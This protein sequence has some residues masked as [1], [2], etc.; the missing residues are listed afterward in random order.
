VVKYIKLK[1]PNKWKVTMRKSIL[2][3]SILIFFSVYVLNNIATGQTESKVTEITESQNQTQKTE[4]EQSKT[5][6]DEVTKQQMETLYTDQ[7]QSEM[8]VSEMLKLQKRIQDIK[9]EKSS[10]IQYYHETMNKL[11]SESEELEKKLNELYEIEQKY[12]S[13]K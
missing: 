6:I 12:K 3:M 8:R 5:R 10:L 2:F 11:T 9:S 1:V 13:K 7:E 4:L